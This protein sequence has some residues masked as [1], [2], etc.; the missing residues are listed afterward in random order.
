LDQLIAFPGKQNGEKKNKKKIPITTVI[1]DGQLA[2][3]VFICVVLKVV[4]F[5]AIK[6][7]KQWVRLIKLFRGFF[8]CAF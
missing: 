5:F 6:L 3:K 2:Y 1:E 4:L 8:F 7:K